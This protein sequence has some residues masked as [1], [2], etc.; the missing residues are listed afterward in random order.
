MCSSPICLLNVHS[1]IYLHSSEEQL[2]SVRLASTEIQDNCFRSLSGMEEGALWPETTTLVIQRR[3][4]FALSPL[5]TL[6]SFKNPKMENALRTSALEIVSWEPTIPTYVY[7]ISSDRTH[8]A[9]SLL[10]HHRLRRP[11]LPHFL[12]QQQAHQPRV[13]QTIL[14]VPQL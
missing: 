12:K 6:E 2:V 5:E 9:W 7:L 1:Q 8:P 11:V 10:R 14:P 4:V 3:P 13:R